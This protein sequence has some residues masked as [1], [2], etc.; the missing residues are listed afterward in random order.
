M[1]LQSTLDNWRLLKTEDISLGYG[2][3][4]LHDVD[5]KSYRINISYDAFAA[6]SIFRDFRP[7]AGRVTALS[8]PAIPLL[9]FLEQFHD[10][11]SR[12]PNFY[13]PF[14]VKVI[15]E[16]AVFES[17]LLSRRSPLP[18][19]S[20]NETVLIALSLR[21]FVLTYEISLVAGSL[22][23]RSFE[24]NEVYLRVEKIF[25]RDPSIEVSRSLNISQV[26][27]VDSK[28]K[29]KESLLSILE[30]I[31][32]TTQRLMFR[33]KPEDWPLLLCTLF[34]I[35]LISDNLNAYS[36]LWM[37]SLRPTSQ[38]MN[39]V[40]GTLCRLYDICSK[41]FHPLSGNWKREE[42]AKL[43]NYDETLVDCFQWINDMWLKGIRI[44][45]WI[46]YLRLKF[47]TYISGV[48]DAGELLDDYTL[49]RRIDA[50]LNGFDLV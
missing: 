48:N 12:W 41:G 31:L 20:S 47:L 3:W 18:V 1:S 40:F 2:E 23:S 14:T 9:D 28:Q 43:V 19:G 25:E 13:E 17:A 50:F 34:L 29:G 27:F 39:S 16:C 8:Q 22:S 32:Q 35:N 33:R 7:I 11:D 21:C 15:K 45:L 37:R 44:S 4:F 5:K 26:S 36:S 49:E 10:V 38:V 42:Y 24:D 46:R 6:K 30:E